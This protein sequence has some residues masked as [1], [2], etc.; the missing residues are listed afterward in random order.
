MLML[1]F[2]V[3]LGAGCRERAETEGTKTS[4]SQT[5]RPVSLVMP[6]K[7]VY[8]GA[9]V[10][11]G[12]GE[13]RVTYDALTA[14]E[15]LTGKPLAVVAC[16]NFW[17]DQAFPEKTVRII[18]GYGAVPFLFWSPWDKP[19]EES[20]GPDRFGLRE[21]LAGKWDTYIDTWA[22][23][24][25]QYGKPLLIAWGLEMN[26]TWFPWSG[27]F[28]GGG[29]VAGRTKDG[30]ALYEGPELYKRAYRYVVDRVRARKATNILWGFHA[31]NFSSPR[32]PWN[33]MSN[34]Y[35]G[36][37]YVDWLGLSVYGKMTR[38]E[39]WAEFGDMMAVPYAEICALDAAKPVFVAEWGVGEYPPGDKAKFIATA[40]RDLPGTYQRVRLAV[41]WH[42]RWENKDNTFSNLRVNSS[43]EALEAYRTGIA[44]PLWIGRPQFT[45]Q[46][47]RP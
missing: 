47:P 5:G 17:G 14:F 27:S 21:I 35:P 40:L 15:R 33:Q 19:Y 6:Q 38:S 26:G 24:A 22:D 2:I 20:R 30:Q 34:Y 42:E 29:K 28:Y 36:A 12:E 13:S 25:R 32:V 7:G 10:D 4:S 41:Y 46:A 45:Q 43:P 9:Y 3:S 16:G 8:T 18:T 23:A 39:G 11:F 31:N 1:L 44:S 37:D